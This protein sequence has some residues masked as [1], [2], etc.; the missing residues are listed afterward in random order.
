M[1]IIKYWLKSWSLTL[2]D[3]LCD[4]E[5]DLYLISLILCFL[6]CLKTKRLDE[7]MYMNLL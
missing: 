1:K 5:R 3:K 6:I 7:L 4:L 2:T